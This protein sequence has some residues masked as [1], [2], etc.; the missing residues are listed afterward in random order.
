[1]NQSKS[2]SPDLDQFKSQFDLAPETVSVCLR[3]IESSAV[4]GRR[5]KR[6]ERERE[7]DESAEDWEEEVCVLIQLHEAQFSQRW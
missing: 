7:Q 3:P 5:K 2:L 1:M 4:R 6:R